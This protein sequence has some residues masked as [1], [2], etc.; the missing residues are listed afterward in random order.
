MLQQQQ[1]RSDSR[2]ELS[3]KEKGKVALLT[4]TT[5]CVLVCCGVF[6]P[7]GPV[8]VVTDVEGRC[9]TSFGLMASAG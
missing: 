9:L 5:G 3:T 2:N 1:S 6:E 7:D 4:Q 8:T